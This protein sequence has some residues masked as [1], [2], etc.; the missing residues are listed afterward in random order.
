[1]ADAVWLRRIV[2]VV[3]MLL[4]ASSSA[5]A[6]DDGVWSVSKSSGEVWISSAGAEQVSIKQDT[7]SGLV[8]RDVN[9]LTAWITLFGK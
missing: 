4:G 8:L 5:L 6:G 1:M 9:F 3:A 2:V 7:L